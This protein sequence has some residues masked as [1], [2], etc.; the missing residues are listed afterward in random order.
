MKLEIIAEVGS[1]HDGSFGNAIKAIEASS[2]SGATAV[3]FQT[4]IA[5]AESLETA[6]S[7]SYFKDESRIEYFN[8][9]SFSR[10]QWGR[11][12]ECCHTNNVDFVSSPFSIEA[13]DLLREIGCDTLKI[14][15]GEVTNSP[16]LHHIARC[17]Y[18]IYISS[19]MSSWEEMDSAM[20][21]LSSV[22]SLIPM[23]CTSSYPCPPDKVGL[24]V[25]NEMRDRY[26]RSVGF[27]DHTTGS[28]ASIAAV[29]LGAVAVEKHVTFSRLMYGSDA[30]NGMEF[31]EF[32]S[33]CSQ[34]REALLMR[35]SPVNKDDL[36]SVL[37][38]KQIFEKSIVSS[39]HI[40]AGSVLQAGDLAYKKPGTGIQAK[41]FN[42]VIGKTTVRD[43]PA[44]K[45]IAWTDL[46]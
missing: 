45:M 42:Q 23:Q 34:L 37:E 22:R 19:G 25:L 39:R 6:P 1:I 24:N 13:V 11:L 28:T 8:R 26:K 29:A 18:K 12:R 44:N 20:G 33:F 40:Q 5:E 30:G 41:D 32:S 31:S 36:G 7:P 35:S 38:M 2:R 4:H 10:E 14:A 21:I 17:D 16:L 27:S 3:K 46:L 9:T 15:S 43:I